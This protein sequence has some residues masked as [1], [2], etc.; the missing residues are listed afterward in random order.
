ME[1]NT[2]QDSSP[3]KMILTTFSIQIQSHQPEDQAQRITYVRYNFQKVYIDSY[4]WTNNSDAS[5]EV[6]LLLRSGVLELF[7]FCQVRENTTNVGIRV[8]IQIE[9]IF[10]VVDLWVQKDICSRDCIT[11]YIVPS[12]VIVLNQFFQCLGS[13]F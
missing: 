1:K 6:L 12:F 13:S 3:V 9:S 2:E 7:N 4:V 8:Q 10:G 5:I 11:K